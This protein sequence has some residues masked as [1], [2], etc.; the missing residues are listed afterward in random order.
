MAITRENILEIARS[1]PPAPRVFSDLDRLLLDPDNALGP[2]ADLI[3]RDA[4]LAGHLIRVGNS[5]AYGGEQRVGSVEEAVARL[6]FQRTFR[7]VGEAAGLQLAQRALRHYGI[8]AEALREHMLYTAFACEQLALECGGDPRRAYTAGLLRPLGLLVL[9]RL[10]DRYPETADYNSAVDADFLAWEGRS[11]GVASP[12]VAALAL[13]DWGFPAETLEAVRNHYLLRSDDLTHPLACVLHLASG[14]VADGGH[15]L[16]GEAR[17]WGRSPW[18]REAVGLTEERFQAAAA[19]A[20]R[21]FA[22]F[23]RRRRGEPDPASARPPAPAPD[24]S[25]PPV[26]AVLLDPPPPAGRKGSAAAETC[27]FAP[28]S[29]VVEAN[30]EP[31]VHTPPTGLIPPADFTTFMLAY[32]D[33]VFSTAARLTGN[34]AQAEDISQ[35]VF[36]KAHEHF[37]Q[38]RTSPTAGGW[39]KTVATNL[40]LNHLSRYRNRWKFFSEFKRDDAAADDAGIEFAAPGDFFAAVDAGERRAWVERALDELPDHQRVPLVLYHFEELP[41]EDIARK[42]GVSLAKV[43]TDILRARAALAKILQRS[44]TAHEKLSP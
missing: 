6:G 14:V 29:R 26:P 42:L 30:D 11:F 5:V 4:A 3:K 25:G 44:G 28:A 39:L 36:L 27:N 1:L 23:Q 13:A 18:K 22:D 17:H 24:R 43:K 15:G 38:L 20:K 35:E 21:A 31:P 2:I 33:M 32:Q 19:R 41:Y 10:A 34:E 12:E 16:P 7:L 37:D 40:S 9:D 8:T